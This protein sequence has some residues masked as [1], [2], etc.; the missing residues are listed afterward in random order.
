MVDYSLHLVLPSHSCGAHYRRF[1]MDV[2][3][4]R[5]EMAVVKNSFIS[6]GYYSIFKYK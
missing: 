6:F 5:N 1:N 2:R 4:Y 3:E